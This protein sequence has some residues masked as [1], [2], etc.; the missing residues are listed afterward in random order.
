MMIVST[1]WWLFLITCLLLLSS[2]FSSCSRKGFPFD[3]TPAEEVESLAQGSPKPESL[4]S[5][6]ASEVTKS[7]YYNLSF[8]N[9]L[10]PDREILKDTTHSSSFSEASLFAEDNFEYAV[11]ET[12]PKT[13]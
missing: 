2:C 8:K 12:T 10:G 6:A 4:K 13:D 1:Y 3:S 7:K 11:P 9:N 5:T